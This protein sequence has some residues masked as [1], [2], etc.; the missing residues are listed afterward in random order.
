[1]TGVSRITY[2]TACLHYVSG[3]ETLVSGLLYCPWC[4]DYFFFFFFKV[5]EWRA[6]CK[7][8]RFARWAG[9]SKEN[10]GIFVTGHMRRNRGH[11]A[12]REYVENL[13]AK[14]TNDKFIAWHNGSVRST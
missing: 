7:H 14:I 3:P 13:A 9:T 5:E 6:A 10:A 12:Y 1:M 4:K 11:V 2:L 8:C